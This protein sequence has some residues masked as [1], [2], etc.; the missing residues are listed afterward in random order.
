MYLKLDM[1]EQ[2]GDIYSF[3]LYIHLTDD[4]DLSFKY[5]GGSKGMYNL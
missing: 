1:Q 2:C 4:G 5:E 3:L